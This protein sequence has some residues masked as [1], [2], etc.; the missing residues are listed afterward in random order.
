MQSRYAMHLDSQLLVAVIVA[1][2]LSLF[3][4]ASAWYA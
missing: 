1:T 4:D 3:G 2:G